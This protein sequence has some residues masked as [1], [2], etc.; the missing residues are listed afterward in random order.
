VPALPAFGEPPVVFELV[1]PLECDP[2]S[3]SS[4]VEP[5]AA[6]T[7]ANAVV[8]AARRICMGG[9]RKLKSATKQEGMAYLSRFGLRERARDKRCAGFLTSRFKTFTSCRAG[10][11]AP[12]AILFGYRTS[13]AFARLAA[14]L[15]A[16]SPGIQPN[17]R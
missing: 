10:A 5:H 2:S 12:A 15:G 6:R 8:L 4:D 17:D 7:K 16:R 1:P 9:G 3:K 13:S 14:S 11:C